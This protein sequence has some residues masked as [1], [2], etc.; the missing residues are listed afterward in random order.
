MVVVINC[1]L[2][3]LLQTLVR[4]VVVFR[5]PVVRTIDF[6]QSHHEGDFLFGQQF[7]RLK[8]LV[9]KAMLKIDNQDGDVAETGASRSEVAE[10]FVPRSVDNEQSRNVDISGEEI[11]AFVHFKHKLLFGEESGSYLLC[12]ASSL[13]F[14]NIGLSDLVQ[15]SS[16][17]SI[18]MT[19]DAADWA[20]VLSCL[21]GEIES[22]V[23]QQLCLHL[24]LFLLM[25]NSPNFFFF[26]Q[27]FII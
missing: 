22:V 21:S 1:L 7:Q 26:S 13:T 20:S 5:F 2:L 14:L 9:L 17:S 3:L 15:K 10:T 16:F 24:F 18:D 19:Q 6:V 27:L 25:Q 12:D 11:F 4:R 8:G 23:L